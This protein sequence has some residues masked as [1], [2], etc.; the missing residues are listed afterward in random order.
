M[1]IYSS[2][3]L[4]SGATKLYRSLLWR[5]HYVLYIWLAVNIRSA[6]ARLLRDRGVPTR[7]KMV[8]GC[9]PTLFAMPVN[10]DPPTFEWNAIKS[11]PKCDR[12]LPVVAIL[13]SRIYWRTDSR[14]I[15]SH[16]CCSPGRS[17]DT[18]AIEGYMYL[19]YLLRALPFVTIVGW[20]IFHLR[21]HLYWFPLDHIPGCS[22]ENEGRGK[23]DISMVR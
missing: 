7:K 2:N 5:I 19:V 16:S 9:L 18:L 3:D 1:A 10:I 22:R 12:C 4:P 8:S 17:P 23:G 15:G 20:F 13:V 6:S 11:Y 21:H 14:I